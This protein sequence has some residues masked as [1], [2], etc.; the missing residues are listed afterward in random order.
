MYALIP[1]T[2][3]S[4]NPHFA[5]FYHQLT[6]QHIASDGTTKSLAE[7]AK[8]ARK[9]TQEVYFKDKI[10]YL[11]NLALYN[12]LQI[13]AMQGEEKAENTGL[14]HN[15]KTLLALDQVLSY[16]EIKQHWTLSSAFQD[17]DITL[18]GLQEE[19]LCMP[20]EDYLRDFSILMQ[21]SKEEILSTVENQLIKKCEEIAKFYYKEESNKKLLFA[22]AIQLN[23]VVSS[24]TENL[25]SVNLDALNDKNRLAEL[26]A[27]YLKVIS[28]I[29]IDLWTMLEEFKY[30]NEFEKNT[31]F[32]DYFSSI[33]KSILL[34]LRVLR[35][36]AL[37]TIYDQD[38]NEALKSIRDHLRIEEKEKSKLLREL[39]TKLADYQSI[40]GEFEKVVQEYAE[41]IKEIEVT[42]DD[43]RRIT[44]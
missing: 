26:L 19:D 17:S 18:L 31:I 22:K 27:D 15:K 39:N 2:L 28:E 13:L 40:G 9:C 30:R 29:L 1:R 10:E 25:R 34:K 3:L 33:V 44:E 37:M 7:E 32:D 14:T 5:D 8:K 41:V 21:I 4:S 12:E 20:I 43:I 6:T 24:R 42:E 11:E 23:K 38:T 16:S 36:N 35:I